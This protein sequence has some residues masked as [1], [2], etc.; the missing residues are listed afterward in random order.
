MIW[1]QRWWRST[2]F[3]GSGGHKPRRSPQARLFVEG[4]ET[5]LMPASVFVVPVSQLV[6]RRVNGPAGVGAV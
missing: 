3:G 2:R 5:R 4:L 1:S 6:V